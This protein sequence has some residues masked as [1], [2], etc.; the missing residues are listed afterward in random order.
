MC[1]QEHINRWRSSEDG[2]DRVPLEGRGSM[3]RLP[4]L[5]P[6]GQLSPQR[7]SWH[8]WFDILAEVTMEGESSGVGGLPGKGALRGRR[9]CCGGWGK[10][11]MLRSQGEAVAM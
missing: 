4:T 9:L 7:G 3:K 5:A 8:S 11:E 2:K 1:G 10:G 6:P